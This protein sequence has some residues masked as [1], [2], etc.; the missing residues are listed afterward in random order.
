MKRMSLGLGL[1]FLIAQTAIGA[2][3]YYFSQADLGSLGAYAYV[4]PTGYTNDP[5][6][7][8]FA[9]AT[10][11]PAYGATLPAGYVGYKMND[12]GEYNNFEY[13]AIGK[14]VDLT[15]CDAF[16]MLLRNDDN[17]SWQYELFAGQAGTVLYHTG[18][19]S[20]FAPGDESWFTL[21]FGSDLSGFYDIGFRIGRGDQADNMHT[22]SAVVPAPGAIMLAGLGTGLVGW[23]R[24]RRTL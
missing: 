15:G 6:A 2:G 23:F 9:I 21:S 13:V 24:R 8:G 5:D 3:T 12:V 20:P 1:C 11:S 17:Q 7:G 16:G 4:S 10:N 22:S 14:N 18:L 19:S